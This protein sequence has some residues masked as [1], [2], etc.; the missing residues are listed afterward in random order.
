MNAKAGLAKDGI[1]TATCSA[2]VFNELE[3][4]ELPQ[5]GGYNIM[6]FRDRTL[7]KMLQKAVAKQN[8]EEYEPWQKALMRAV[9][10]KCDW[11]DKAYLN[12]LLDYI[13]G[14]SR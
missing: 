4:E 14:I 7:C 8:P 10:K 1:K 3:N 13:I 5:V 9:G 12:P 6:T 11:T 2:F